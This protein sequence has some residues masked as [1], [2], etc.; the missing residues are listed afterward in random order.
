MAAE[1]VRFHQDARERLCAELN[2]LARA[3]EVT[4]GPC[5]RVMMLQRPYGSAVVIKRASELDMQEA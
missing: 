2:R 4:L 3:V 5:G 1:P